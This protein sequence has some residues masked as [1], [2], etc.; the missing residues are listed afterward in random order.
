MKCIIPNPKYRG[1]A[2][3]FFRISDFGFRIF[4]SGRL[5]V[6]A[7]RF[8]QDGFRQLFADTQARVANLA[9]QIRL[10]A[11]QLHD[12]FFAEAHF[13]QAHPNFRRPGQLLDANDRTRFNAAQ[14]ANGGPGAF[15]INHHTGLR[16]RMFAH[17]MPK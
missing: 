4:I 12:L 2:S 15:A 13:S 9:N 5:R 17:R 8:D 6:G 11:D 14:R 1:S 3:D 7:D 16:F 10:M